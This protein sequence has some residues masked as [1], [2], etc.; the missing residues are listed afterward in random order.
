MRNPRSQ[1]FSSF[2][3]VVVW[4]GENDTKTLVWMMKYFVWIGKRDCVVFASIH[5]LKPNWQVLLNDW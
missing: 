1:S 3:G 4:I 2:S 5:R